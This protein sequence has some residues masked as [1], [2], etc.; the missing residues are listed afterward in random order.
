M[1]FKIIL[2][3]I[4]VSNVVFAADNDRFKIRNLDMNSEE[5][6]I[7]PVYF[8]GR[9]VYAS[10]R[11]LNTEVKRVWSRTNLGYYDLYI[12]DP[13]GAGELIK[14]RYF[15]RKLNMK[16][17]EGPLS[18]NRDG[19]FMAFTQNY[20]ESKKIMKLKIMTSS[21]QDG[22]WD[23][24]IHVPFNNPDYSVGHPALNHDAT[25]MYFASD[26]PGGYGGTDI[27]KV[28][29]NDDG[30]WGRPQNMG[31][32]INTSGNE[33]FPFIH[34]DGLLFFSSDGHPGMGGLD[35]F[36]AHVSRGV[37]EVEHLDAPVN[38]AADDFSFILSSDQY[39]GY[40]SSN[41]DEG[42]GS[43]DIYS[44]TNNKKFINIAF[45][46]GLV[47][48]NSG[49]FIQNAKVSLMDAEG[50]EVGVL[51]S[52]GKGTFNFDLDPNKPYQLVV[53]KDGYFPKIQNISELAVSDERSLNITLD[54]DPSISLL[55]V[56]TDKKTGS[57]VSNAKVKLIDIDNGTE[58]VMIANSNGIFTK[59]LEEKRLNEK[60]NY[61]LRIEAEGYLSVSVNYNRLLDKEGQYD[62]NVEVDLMLEKIKVGE[63]KLEDIVEVN[64]IFWD[65][66]SF[67]V[68]PDAALELDKIVEAMNNNPN[69]HIELGSHTDSRGSDKQ[70]LQLSDQ[71]AKAA[72]EYIKS[73]ITNPER[74]TYRGYGETQLKNKCKDGVK[75]S[76]EEHQENRRTEFRITKF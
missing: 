55:G 20:Y 57:P 47:A 50:A 73:K 63:T 32:K 11:D 53:Q 56:V 13:G 39:S 8:N 5:S 51:D 28:T 44:F 67:K 12:G 71:R 1:K 7:A 6:D 14:T 22:K 49:E 9:V 15:N 25:V 70:N 40:F 38:S 30:T 60:I 64:A 19:D 17:N 36:V 48:D 37:G 27:Y 45:L 3:F 72:S 10:S 75:C 26:M 35:I 68:R 34:R 46:K 74:I 24:P 58:E 61:N 16:Y 76:E 29:R 59:K 31:D 2:L 66:G 4:V 52:D 54:K 21:L 69:V 65:L 42:K 33:M 18:F 43:D 62:L 23:E 41:R